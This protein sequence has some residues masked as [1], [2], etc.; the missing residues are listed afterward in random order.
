MPDGLLTPDLYFRSRYGTADAAEAG[1]EWLL[2]E[3][4]DGAWQ[5]PLIVRTINDE[6]RDATSPYG[7][8][9]VYADN[10]IGP[11]DITNAYDRTLEALRQL[12]VVSVF[13]RHSP[14][15][16]QAPARPGQL[17]VVADHPTVAVGVVDP[18]L[19]WS[20]LEGRCRTSVRKAIKCGFTA[21]VRHA[22]PS[23]L[24]PGAPFRTL[25]EATMARRGAREL[26]LFSD[27][28][29][30]DLLS[31]LQEDLLISTVHSADGDVQAAAL[32]MRH[33]NFLHYHLSGSTPEAARAGGNNLMLWHAL[34]YA[35]ENGVE[36]FHL[37]GG[38][39]GEDAL[40]KFKRSFGGQIRTYS[41]SGLI[42]NEDR[43]S[44]LSCNDW[45]GHQVDRALESVDF[46]PSYRARVT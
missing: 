27:A 8:S 16:S 2:V 32:L 28:Y 40:F 26:Y 9:G 13:V 5:I 44:A 22:A 30:Q 34:E 25:Y 15:V 43:Y 39:K 41:A 21:D 20:R 3:A 23:D 33:A 45:Q 12:G 7:Y 37:G 11:I 4:F 6:D 10:A 17:S 46:F 1:G 36:L 19:M 31:A 35:A 18:E 29:Y 24:A 14:L 38:L 42:V